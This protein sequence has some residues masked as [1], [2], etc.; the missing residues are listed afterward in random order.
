MGLPLPVSCSRQPMDKEKPIQL[1]LR[2]RSR[3]SAPLRM[4]SLEVK[5]LVVYNR[6]SLVLTLVVFR[7]RVSLMKRNKICTYG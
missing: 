5:Q 4:V 3:F 7:W 1:L 2:R 6:L